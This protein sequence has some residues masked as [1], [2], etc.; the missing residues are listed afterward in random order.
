MKILAVKF[1]IIFICCLPKVIFGQY[2][3][4]PIFNQTEKLL[5][6]QP[7]SAFKMLNKLLQE[8]LQKK[9]EMKTAIC[10]RQ[11]GLIFY[12]QGAFTQALD[13]YNKSGKIFKNS[14]DLYYAE[15]LNKIGQTY[16]YNVKRKT[17]LS[18]YNKALMIFKKSNH[19]KGIAETYGLIGQIYEKEKKLDSALYFQNIA[20]KQ[21]NQ[22]NDWNGLAKINEN[23][24]S[25]YE[26][27]SD[28]KV[29]F[30]FYQK[31]LTINQKEKNQIAQIEILNNLGDMYRKTSQFDIA[32]TYSFRAKNW[33]LK[34]KDF[35]EL[36]SAYRDIAKTFSFMGRAD[37]A[38]FYSL[39]EKKIYAQIFTESSNKQ[40]ALLETIFSVQE[41]DQEISNL[42]NEKRV[43]RII[44]FGTIVIIILVIVI[45]FNIIN[46]QK[47]RIDNESK[48]LES[49]RIL[50]E[51]EKRAL[52]IEISN[53]LIKEDHLKLELELKSKELTTHTLHII[54]KNQLLEELKSKLNIILKD[55]KRDQKKEIKTVLGL[56]NQS[57]NQDNNWEDFRIIF[58]QVHEKFFT[59]LKIR[60]NNLTPSDFR[61]LALFKM[62][63]GSSDIATILGI[64]QD[65]LRTSRYRLRQK[66][67]LAEGE[68]LLQFIQ[69]L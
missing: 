24:G 63:L 22:L 12:N 67:N 44:I 56:I 23:L 4:P 38:Y 21:Y 59:E 57:N 30:N 32:L 28:F 31:A 46:K 13:C 18:N 37:S 1:I 60:S 64:S 16:Y 11:I 35:Y 33:A 69:Q 19:K 10:Y 55:E 65:S 53:K 26:D 2:Q 49:K 8:S 5:Q 40:M 66:L 48:L 6:S 54:Q 50:H 58:E 36:S 62:N 39:E 52:E 41:K 25:I 20:L 27:K 15:I 9:D 68:N 61:L 29:A 7:D 17:A 34:Y 51:T 47:I 14:N 43:N 42:E 45:G 3:A